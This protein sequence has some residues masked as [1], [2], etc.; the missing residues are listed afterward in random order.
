MPQSLEND[1][2]DEQ[3]T[4][5]LLA[6]AT[7]QSDLSEDSNLGVDPNDSHAANLHAMNA[8]LKRRSAEIDLQVAE[9]ARR[10]A[11]LEVDRAAVEVDRRMLRQQ[12]SNTTIP[13]ADVVVAGS[14]DDAQASLDQLKCER[15]AW[16]RERRGMLDELDLQRLDLAQRVAALEKQSEELE[17]RHAALRQLE[18]ACDERQRNQR[19]EIEQLKASLEEHAEQ[20]ARQHEQFKAL[21]DSEKQRAESVRAELDE[22]QRTLEVNEEQF[23]RQRAEWEDHRRSEALREEFRGGSSHHSALS[24]FKRATTEPLTP[25]EPLPAVPARTPAS[26][27][28]TLSTASLLAKYGVELEPDAPEQSPATTRSRQVTLSSISNE[29]E[30]ASKREAVAPTEPAAAAEDKPP[31]QAPAA[32]SASTHADSSLDDDADINA[33]MAQLLEKSR[34]KSSRTEP[35][36]SPAPAAPAP[37]AERPIQRPISEGSSTAAPRE[38][39]RLMA[40]RPAAT[41]QAV[42]LSAL[43]EVANMNARAAINTHLNSQVSGATVRALAGLAVGLLAVALFAWRHLSG[44][45]WAWYAAGAGLLGAALIVMRYLDVLRRIRRKRVRFAD[46]IIGSPKPLPGSPEADR[47]ATPS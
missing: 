17:R 1:N 8:E 27:G 23:R 25:K 29:R 31:E 16:Q 13:L 22:R 7:P 40:P 30:H 46:A 18:R 4:Y 37:V 12:I 2:A 15:E 35:I 10:E 44:D 14:A 47:S 32:P 3:P 19:L 5:S 24:I 21:Q 26:S 33:Y 11:Q 6:T 41:T 39:N 20:L 34:G 36:S 28:V 9:L 43:R 42:N 45:W 38:E